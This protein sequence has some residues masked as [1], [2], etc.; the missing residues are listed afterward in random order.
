MITHLDSQTATLCVDSS[1]PLLA[2]VVVA[3]QTERERKRER[4]AHTQR[5]VHGV[6]CHGHR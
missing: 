5:R 6:S 4:G 3:R 2:T 1:R